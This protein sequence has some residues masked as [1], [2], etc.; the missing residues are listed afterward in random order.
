MQYYSSFIHYFFWSLIV[1]Q[2]WERQDSEGSRC[3]RVSNLF[4]IN[5]YY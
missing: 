3:E 5:G 4:Y 2:E 1:I